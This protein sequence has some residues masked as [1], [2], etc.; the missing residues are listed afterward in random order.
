MTASKS[1][2]GW[3]PI[4]EGPAQDGRSPFLWGRVIAV[5]ADSSRGASLMKRGRGARSSV[6]GAPNRDPKEVRS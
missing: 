2:G 3:R 6:V 5:T 4:P 1:R